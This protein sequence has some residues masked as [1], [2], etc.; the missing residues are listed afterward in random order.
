MK[1]KITEL[2]GVD[3]FNDKIMSER[4]PAEIYERLRRTREMGRSLDPT[5]ANEVARVMKEWA[6]ENG[7]THYTH[8]FQPLTGITAEKHDSFVH[9]IE[10]GS[11]VPVFSG[12]ELIKGESDASSFPNGG[13]RATFEAR[14]Y[15]AWDPTACAFVKDGVLCIPTVF[16]SYGGESLDKKTPLLRSI[17][18]LGKQALRIL[19]LFGDETTKRVVPSVGAEQEY[20]LV[21]KEDY[22]KRKD[23]LYTGRTLF[24]A[25]P[26]KGQQL[27]DHYFGS[28]K[29]RVKAFM[30]D[31]DEALWRLGVTA[32]TEHN[33]AAPAQHEL[34]PLYTDNNTA[35]DHNQIMMDVM[36]RVASDHGLICLLHEKPFDGVNGSGKH[37]NWSLTTNEGVNLLDP[38]ETP[39][40]NAQ[41]LVFLAAVIAAV[42]DYQDL[43]RIS[44]A[45]AGNDRRL[46]GD[47]AP[48][49]ILSM[50]LGDE[51]T[52]VLEAIENG[53][54]YHDEEK[55]VMSIGVHVLPKFPK[56][57]S[58]RNRTSPFAFTGNKFEFRMPGSSLSIAGPN[59]ILNTIVAEELSIFADELEAAEDFNAALNDL[60]RRQITAHKRII[61]SGNGYTKDW[62]AEAERR[63]LSNYPTCADALPH[64]CD[65][66]NIALF[67][68]HRIYTE[69]ELRSRCDI[70]LENYVTITEIEG[71]TMAEMI[72]K[73]IIPASLRYLELLMSTAE[74][75]K[76]VN[77]SIST[78]LEEKLAVKLSNLNEEL[79]LA[80][81]NIESF[82]R[83]LKTI[84]DYK[85]SAEFCRDSLIPE[86]NKA[87]A[88]ADEI[89]SSVDK[90]IWP[91]PTYGDILFAIH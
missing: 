36:K 73:E 8:W 23:L 32:K 70:L 66:K 34:A 24:G 84:D 3:V 69:K 68:K 29:P 63:G 2:F 10:G 53:N 40:E 26:C 19:R 12:K 11:A 44:V 90:S 16:C 89:E 39:A 58:D 65:E 52:S 78:S 17:E 67:E 45:T 48:P 21:R 50:F 22:L 1:D 64:M 75:K 71:A 83:T 62:V 85:L 46:G 38:G 61:Y 33:E 80:C 18:R 43:L 87:R 60:I 82:G 14:G 37:N 76:T 86:M 27:N 28:I 49:A 57:T 42:D 20:F 47:E 9:P 15:T 54:E 31:L 72:R 4:L 35:C 91:Y 7:A 30:D 41:F 6:V 5:V 77:A 13:L 81:D 55:G 25:K 74:K 88:F 59:T 51:L 79:Y 56:D